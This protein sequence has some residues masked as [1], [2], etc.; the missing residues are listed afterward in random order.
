MKKVLNLLEIFSISFG[1]II[2][3]TFPVLGLD[4]IN[5]NF[6]TVDAEETIQNDD[7]S[8]ISST[9]EETNNEENNNK[10]SDNEFSDNN[11]E[12][13]I[14]GQTSFVDENGDITTKDV[15]D[16]TTGEEFNPNAKVVTTA[17]MVN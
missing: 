1:L 12:S 2:G 13:E 14:I 6:E 8:V 5:N 16:G 4:E 3:N 7:K 11:S 17:N 15:Y 9:N 10:E